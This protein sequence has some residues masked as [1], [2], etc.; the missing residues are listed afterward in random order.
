MW[1]Y[2]QRRVECPTLKG[3]DIDV[4]NGIEKTISDKVLLSPHACE[5]DL[6][7]IVDYFEIVNDLKKGKSDGGMGLASDHIIYGTPK[8]AQMLTK[9]FN[10]MIIHGVGPEDMCTGTMVP[11]P[12][13]KRADICNSDNYRGICLQSQLCKLLDMFMLRREAPSLITSDLQFGFKAKMSATMATTVVTETVDYYLSQEGNVYGLALDASKAFDRVEYGKLFKMLLDRNFNIVYMRLLLNMYINQKMR[14]RFN[15]VYSDYFT[16]GNGVKQ[17]GVISPTLFT[18]Y[19]DGMLQKLKDSKLGCNVGSHY[20]GCVSYADDLM[21]LA[22]T[23]SSLNG[24]IDICESYAA[25]YKIKFNGTKSKLMFFTK[26]HNVCQ[27]NIYVSGEPVE[28]VTSLKYLGHMLHSDRNNSHVGYIRKEFIVKFNSFMGD[29]YE[30]SSE[31]KNNL[32]QKY[33][34]CFYGSQLANLA[35]PEINTILA[36]WRKAVR[37]ILGVP[38]RTHSNL[39]YH[40][41][42]SPPLDV[43]LHQRFIKYFYAG[44]T[45]HNVIVRDIFKGAVYLPTQMGNNLRHVLNKIHMGVNCVDICTPQHINNALLEMW[46]CSCI[47]SDIRVAF[48]INEVICMRDTHET[49]ILNRAECFAIIN[50]LCTS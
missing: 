13:G 11:I 39:L 18:C 17:G 9:L 23:L 48:H 6:M 27:P 25:E 12:K 50:C 33:C 16:V 29:F 5:D 38:P 41:V 14:V 22:P 19:V 30:L 1:F 28:N 32:F 35:S 44:Y 10:T 36:E 43:I 15:D 8:L 45:S 47:E 24:M 31:I 46:M 3:Y 49:S 34:M 2:Q 42:G 21:L 37:R 7:T 40:V 4:I 20:I 26:G